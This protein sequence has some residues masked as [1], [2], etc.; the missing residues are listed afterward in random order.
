MLRSTL[1]RNLFPIAL[2]ALGC[3]IFIAILLYIFRAHLATVGWV[4]LGLIMIA[5]GVLGLV[6]SKPKTDTSAGGALTGSAAS[7][8][9]PSPTAAAPK[10]SPIKSKE[11]KP[12]QRETVSISAPVLIGGGV[13]LASLVLV[14]LGNFGTALRSLLTVHK[15]QIVDCSE[16][17]LYA[18]DGWR[19]VSS[20]SYT[21]MDEVSGYAT[22]TD[23]VMER[24]QLV[25][26]KDKRVLK[27]GVSI[28]DLFTDDASPDGASPGGIPTDTFAPETYWTPTQAVPLQPSA[29]PMPLPSSTPLAA[30]SPLPTWTPPPSSASSPTDTPI[31][32]SPT[33]SPIPRTDIDV[34]EAA[35]NDT[36]LDTYVQW[37]GT[38]L[39]DPTFEDAGL[40]FQVQWASSDPDNACTFFVSYDSSER[41]F[42]EDV[43]AV[44]GTIVDTKYEYEGE[45]GQTEYTVVV[46]AAYV[47]FLDEP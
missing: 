32:P 2:I 19:F 18:E 38:I 24:E 33:P 21:L 36:Y 39:A 30:N 14:L 26:A 44:T 10:Y 34:C 22:R 8:R 42:E 29:T 12:G 28:D 25:W 4:V 1:K 3:L 13:L 15:T 31:P 41:F 40:W 9:T 46:K 43:V 47:E 16:A 17:S 35:L 6:A 23:C 27:D 20:Y 7:A 11:I 45:A 37:N 5:V